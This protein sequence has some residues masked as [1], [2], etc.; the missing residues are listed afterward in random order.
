MF[1][2]IAVI[3]FAIGACIAGGA[4]GSGSQPFTPETLALTGAALL[5]A[6]F[7]FGWAPPA[8]PW[9]RQP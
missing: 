5:A 2:V 1:A 7:A 6:H 3:V 4:F 8:W 9:R